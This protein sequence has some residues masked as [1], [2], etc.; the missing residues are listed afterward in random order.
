MVMAV[1]LI[2]VKLI[3]T[4]LN[5]KVRFMKTEKEIKQYIRERWFPDHKAT[6]TKCENLEILDWSKPGTCIY[7]IRFVFDGNYMYITGD[8]GEAVFRLTWK[9]GVHTFNDISTGYFM[10]KLK[11]FSDDKYDFDKEKAEQELKEWKEE[12][13]EDN[14]NIDKEDIENFN[15]FFNELLYELNDCDKECEWAIKINNMS[16]EIEKYIRDYWEWL[17]SIGRTTPYR[18]LGYIVALQM[19]SEQLKGSE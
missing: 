2:Y 9:A 15:I 8:T 3:W 18:I 12:F 4:N 16:D 10:E 13:L 6:L 5:R 19:A 7:A 1:K 17:Y 14:Y 11:A